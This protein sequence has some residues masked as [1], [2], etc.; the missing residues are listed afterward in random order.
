MARSAAA[1]IDFD[2]LAKEADLNLAAEDAA[3]RRIQAAITGWWVR[4]AALT[5]FK[6]SA[7]R[8][9]GVAYAVPVAPTREQDSQAWWFS[10]GDLRHL[11]SKSASLNDQV[12]YAVTVSPERLQDS[13]SWSAS[14]PAQA[15]AQNIHAQSRK[16][17][18]WRAI[19]ARSKARAE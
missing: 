11:I 8:T 13:H 5:L 12:D 6:P 2:A 7:R 16:K 1:T 15:M 19:N 17:L 18:A 14:E 10:G 9:Q 4:G 3:A